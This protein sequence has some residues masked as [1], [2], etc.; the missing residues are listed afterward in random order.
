LNPFSKF[1]LDHRQQKAIALVRGRRV[2]DIGSRREPIADN[3]VSIDIDRKFRPDVCASATHLPFRSDSFDCVTILEV[4]EHLED[5][6]ISRTLSEIK[7]VSANMVLST[8]NC[9]SRVW[10]KIVWPAW[11]HTIGREWID[12]HK[13][14]FGKDGIRYLLEERFDMKIVKT[15]FSHWSLLLLA[16][17]RRAPMIEQIVTAHTPIVAHETDNRR[18]RRRSAV[19]PVPVEQ[20]FE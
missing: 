4:I 19:V 15:N 14:F 3:V 9:D 10:N 13:Q 8:P 18:P 5:R 1:W 12:A 7:R 20:A 6:D 16:R 2:L 11:T 17:T